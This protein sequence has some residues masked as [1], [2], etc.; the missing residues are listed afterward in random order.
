MLSTV[1][2]NKSTI[3]AITSYFNP[4]KYARRLSNFR[5]FRDN[6]QI[7]L[8][9]VELEKNGCFELSSDDGNVVVQLSGEDRIWQK[10]RLLNIAIN[11][12][13][14][15]VEYVAWIDCDLIF[16]D[17]DWPEQAVSKLDDDHFGLVQLFEEAAHLSV[18]NSTQFITLDEAKPATPILRERSVG[19]SL[20]RGTFEFTG[21][22]TVRCN[23]AGEISDIAQ[24]AEVWGMAWAAKVENMKQAG[25]YDANIIGGGDAITIMASLGLLK[26]FFETRYFSPAHKAHIDN[27]AKRTN[28]QLDRIGYI[29]GRV[30]HLW[31]GDFTNRKYKERYSMLKGFDPISDLKTARNGTWEWADSKSKL[32]RDVANYFVQRREDG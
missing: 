13:P 25:F 16:E 19:A 17:A 5:V 20:E 6:L 31:H 1:Q 26:D 24:T 14:K 11:R 23:A 12:L 32:A 27:W 15:H 29:P 4:E 30:L 21:S 18:E 22:K 8:V 7:P 3:W 10:E 9:V 2:H 28:N